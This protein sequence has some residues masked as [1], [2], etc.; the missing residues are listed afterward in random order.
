MATVSIPEHHHHHRNHH[1]PPQQLG[2]HQ[3]TLQRYLLLHSQHQALRQSIDHIRSTGAST[4]MSQQ[5]AV[6]GMLPGNIA[7]SVFAPEYTYRPGSSISGSATAGSLG[8]G[9]ANEEQRLADINE[10]IKRALTELLNC[11]AVRNDSK[12]RMW[13]QHRLME[14]E[15]ELRSRRRRRSAACP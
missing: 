4:T 11:E 3:F 14:T 5:Q 15:K 7:Y 12:F 1:Q 6:P 10:S 13:V 2:H 8:Y 9:V